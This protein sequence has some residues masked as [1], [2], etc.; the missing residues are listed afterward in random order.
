MRSPFSESGQ[1]FGSSVASKLV[2]NNT[3]DLTNDLQKI[4]TSIHSHKPSYASKN[5]NN[6]IKRA[7]SISEDKYNL[8]DNRSNL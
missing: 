8:N 3:I 4:N 2:P 5:D 7:N 6:P 1:N